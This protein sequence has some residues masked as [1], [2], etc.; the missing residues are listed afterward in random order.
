MFHRI[1]TT[2]QSLPL[3]PA[4]PLRPYLVVVVVVLHEDLPHY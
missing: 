3:D 2:A 4:Q 1:I